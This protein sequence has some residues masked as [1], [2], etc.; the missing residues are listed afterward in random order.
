PR[1]AV[2][3]GAA[4]RHNDRPV[5]S[6]RHSAARVHD[7]AG[8]VAP[9]PHQ[10]AGGRGFQH[11]YVEVADLTCP[12][13]GARGVNAAVRCD[14]DSVA[15]GSVRD[16][17]PDEVAGRI[18]LDDEQ[19]GRAGSEA[20]RGAG[21]IH[22]SIGGCRHGQAFIGRGAAPRPL[23]HSNVPLASNFRRTASFW[24]SAVMPVTYTEPSALTATS[25]RPSP[26]IVVPFQIRCQVSDPSGA[27]FTTKIF[28]LGWPN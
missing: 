14:G 22:R 1:A 12:G 23:P 11:D 15:L 19:A 24:L 27:N 2:G 7:F 4:A 16:S 20:R 10:A 25:G 9:L 21:D 18:E 8:G 26:R 3:R 13:S 6:C 5:G 28:G 17:L